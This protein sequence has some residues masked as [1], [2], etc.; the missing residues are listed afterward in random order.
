MEREVAS[1]VH[2]GAMLI[3]LGALLS[4][5]FFT[6]YVGNNTGDKAVQEAANIQSKV[7]SGELDGLANYKDSV[8]P[9][10]SIYYILSKEYDSVC[11]LVYDGHDYKI[12]ETGLWDCGESKT[13]DRPCDILD[14]YGLNGKATVTVKLLSNSLYS[15]EIQSI[16]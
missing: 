12:K 14:Y 6:V 10:V 16:V 11:E 15:V 7:G 13:F 4:L 2:L 9:K 5:I 1:T 3:L 8:M